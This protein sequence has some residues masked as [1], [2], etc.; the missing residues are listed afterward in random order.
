MLQEIAQMASEFNLDLNL[1][2]AAYCNAI[3]KIY[4]C[5][6]QAGLTL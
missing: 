1:R 3:F 5:Y 2:R 4:K 6:E